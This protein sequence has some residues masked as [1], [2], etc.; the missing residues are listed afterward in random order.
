MSNTVTDN[1]SKKKIQQLL[2]AV[3]VEPEE[4]TKQNIEAFDYNWNQPHYFGRKQ[5]KKLQAFAEKAATIMTEKLTDCCQADFNVTITSTSEHFANEFLDPSSDSWQRD[6]FL[7][8]GAD[9]DNSCGLVGIPLETAVV[10]VAQ[11]LGENKSEENSEKNLSELEESLLLDVVSCFVEAFCESCADLGLLTAGKVVTGQ[12]PLDLEGQEE[13]FKIAFE[14]KKTE[15]KNASKAYFL[16]PCDELGPV[17]GKT[18]QAAEMFS[19]A[20]I[21]EAILE[22][23]QQMQVSVMAQLGSVILPFEHVLNLEVD[24]IL[25]LSKKVDEPVKLVVE[26]LELFRGMLAKSA[27]QYALVITDG[28][29]SDNAGSLAQGPSSKKSQNVNPDKDN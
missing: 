1:L 12:F 15:S 16:I 3:G 19:E 10:L 27:G 29:E 14:I 24:D 22:H 26:G 8:F 21:S 9:R 20:Q 5:S 28:P 7:A 18:V 6:Y 11:L 13:L 25:I 4:D 2:A 23:L 17:V